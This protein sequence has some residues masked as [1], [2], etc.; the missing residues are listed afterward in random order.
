MVIDGELVTPSLQRCGVAGVARAEILATQKRVRVRDVGWD[1]LERTS[2]MFLSSSV[3]GMLP[4]R[5]LGGRALAVGP[6][7]RAMQDHWRGL[8]FSMEQAG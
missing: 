6:V 1:E 7:V 2:E 5:E 8:G 3:R 4:V